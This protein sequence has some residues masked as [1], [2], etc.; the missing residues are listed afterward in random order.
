M[1]LIRLDVSKN[2]GTGHYRRMKVLSRQLEEKVIFLINTDDNTN[3]AFSSKDIFITTIDKEF[4][5][6]EILIKKFNIKFILLDLLRYKKNYIEKLSKKF[7]CK[8]IAFHEH[9]DYSRFSS[10]SFNCNF[11]NESNRLKYYSVYHGPKY[12][13]INSKIK[14]FNNIKKK[15]YIYINFGGS[16]PSSFMEKFIEAENNIKTK[17]K[18]ILDIGILKKKSFQIP[19]DNY[20]IRS[21]EQCIFKTMSESKLNIVSAGNIMYESIYFNKKTIVL[22][23]NKH[24][25]KFAK[26]VH[27]KG[28]IKYIGMG[29]NINF[30][31]L[32]VSLKKNNY[33]NLTIKKSNIDILGA[34]RIANLI[35]NLV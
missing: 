27:K 35:K 28:F 14:N 4:Q 29:K 33:R 21:S 1:I 8:I 11:L 6:F 2:I 26:V 15:N 20:K 30:Y 34:N 32:A 5:N 25:E 12:L 19:S 18:F 9:D 13:I 16:D 3:K 22:A 17:E 10:M 24:Q 31:D 23:H 7:N